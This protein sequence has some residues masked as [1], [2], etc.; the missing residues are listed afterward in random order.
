MDRSIAS[1]SI[2]TTAVAEGA[3]DTRSQGLPS[4]YANPFE[5]AQAWV[6]DNGMT[7]PPNTS[8]YRSLRNWFCFKLNQWKKERLGEKNEALLAVYGLDFSQ[9]EA[10]KTGRGNRHS[11]IQ[12]IEML[13]A[14][15]ARR[16]TYDL[17]HEASAD[18]LDWQARLIDRFSDDGASRR[19]KDILETIPD[20]HIGLWRRPGDPPASDIDKAW[21]SKATE[22]ELLAIS[23]APHQGEQHPMMPEDMQQWAS[24]QV[25]QTSSVPT[26][27][28]GWMRGIGLVVNQTRIRVG[29]KRLSASL[30]KRGG[31]AYLRG[32]GTED[33]RISTMKGALAAIRMLTYGSSDKAMCIQF[34]LVPAQVVKIRAFLERLNLTKRF[35]GYD[36]TPCR[37][38]VIANPKAFSPSFMKSIE[39]DPS[40]APAGMR[41][42]MIELGC[43][44]W[45]ITH[46]FG[47]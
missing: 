28:M 26:R 2:Q 42:A 7:L 47:H 22:Y 13:R 36:I 19:I 6:E 35:H 37:M 12:M 41:P 27:A 24:Q 10:L 9:Y 8:E 43:A 45:Q 14:W 34:D 46:K 44:A 11:D 17:S 29:K 31:E 33:R 18:L 40:C 15:K 3:S 1:G 16:N 25:T 38:I 21:W 20:L 32:Y 23:M 5:W 4:E 39:K 30:E